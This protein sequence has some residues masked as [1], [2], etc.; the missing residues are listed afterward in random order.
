MIV[1]CLIFTLQLSATIINI[2]EDQPTIQAG[3]DVAVNGDS[4]IVHPG[5][6]QEMINFDGKNITVASSYLTTQDTTYISQTIIDPCQPCYVVTFENGEDSTSVLYGL[7]ITNSEAFSKGIMC[8]DS[9]PKI[10]LNRILNISD[11]YYSTSDYGGCGISLSNSHATIIN[12]LIMNNHLTIWDCNSEDGGAGI[13][14]ISS[15]PKIINNQIIN[16]SINTIVG[17]EGSTGFGAGIYC[18]S[19]NPFISHNTIQENT[20]EGLSNFGGGI[21]FVFCDSIEI[22]NNLISNNYSIVGGGI[23]IADSDGF[24]R[25]KYILNNYTH[26]FGYGG[27]IVFQDANIS[28]SNNVICNNSSGRGGGINCRTLESFISNNTIC[29]NYATVQGGGFHGHGDS[30]FFYNNIFFGN[31]SATGSQISLPDGY[32]PSNPEFYHN[33]IEGGLNAIQGNNTSLWIYENNINILP[34]FVNPTAGSGYQFNA[35]Y[36][37]WSLSQIS[38]C[39]DT[40]IPDTTGL[41]FPLLDINGNYRIWDGDGNG[42]ATIDMGAYEYGAPPYVDLDDNTIIITPDTFL[43]Q[44]YPNPFNPS[45]TIEFSIQDISQVELTIY[46]IKGQKIKTLVKNE[47]TKGSHSI[48]W[49]GNN[50]NNKSVSSGIYYYKLNINGITEAVKKCLLLK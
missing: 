12:N 36:S 20:M 45:T 19:S 37:D 31:N 24:I 32:Y 39:I 17:E 27:G 26:I 29:N 16:N 21:S 5:N 33:N 1:L 2:P 9:S 30:P 11:S 44:N 48:I 22:S 43:F 23:Y 28:I 25:D 3:I 49:N 38:L 13:Y 8:I 42:V 34:N 50:E 14:C 46:N 4:I 18:K 40:G 15:F 35:L 47:F 7:T 6:Y 10:E 41:N